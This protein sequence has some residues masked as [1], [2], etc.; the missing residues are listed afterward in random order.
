MGCGDVK[1]TWFGNVHKTLLCS[2]SANRTEIIIKKKSNLCEI[3]SFL[4]CLQDNFKNN[5]MLLDHSF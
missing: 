3:F 4:P 5:D 2:F 1:S